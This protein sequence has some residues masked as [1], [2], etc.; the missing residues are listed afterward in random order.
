MSGLSLESVL[1]EFGAY[2]VSAIDAYS[3]IFQLGT[4]FIQS[5]GEPGG[6]WYEDGHIHVDMAEPKTD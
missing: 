6:A 1:L 4:G 5:D 3:D 2:E